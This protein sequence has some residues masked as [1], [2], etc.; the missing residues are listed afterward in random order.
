[1][2]KETYN[3]SSIKALFRRMIK[4]GTMPPEEIFNISPFVRASI[5]KA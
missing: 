2:I 4:E 5:V 3:S 1:M